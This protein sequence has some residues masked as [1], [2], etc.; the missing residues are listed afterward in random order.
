MD[1]RKSDSIRDTAHPYW[2]IFFLILLAGCTVP[3]VR[4]DV[5]SGLIAHYRF[6]NGSLADQEGLH[7]AQG[8]GSSTFTPG[9][10]PNAGESLVLD[11][12]NAIRIPGSVVPRNQSFTVAFWY[13]PSSTQRQTYSAMLYA[14]NQRGISPRIGWRDRSF[15]VF[16]RGGGLHIVY[17]PVGASHQLVCLNNDLGL[18][19]S[20][21]HHIALVFNVQH[22]ML[23]VYQDGRPLAQC[24]LNNGAMNLIVEQLQVGIPL[25]PQLS[26]TGPFVGKFGALRFY[27]RTLSETDVATLFEE[28]L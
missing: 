11:G 17:S 20:L 15:A 8:I 2:L 5:Q 26:D 4:G 21:W 10:S 13:E 23:T 12:T 7:A 6:D 3:H 18:L 22:A 25:N 19:P 27:G 24:N 1:G 9:V 16:W 14:A 28:R